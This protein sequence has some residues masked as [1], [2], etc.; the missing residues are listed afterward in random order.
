MTAPERELEEEEMVVNRDGS[1]ASRVP[2]SS[3]ATFAS[4][5]G[6]R[7]NSEELDVSATT[8][9][10]KATAA[11]TTTASVP[12]SGEN[13]TT[14]SSS[15]FKGQQQPK[16]VN[17]SGDGS[18]SAVEAVESPWDEGE[19]SPSTRVGAR[20]GVVARQVAPKAGTREINEAQSTARV[21][22]STALEAARTA[23]IS[24]SSRARRAEQLE[25]LALRDT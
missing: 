4:P 23:H 6:E 13:L 25:S 17:D 16:E 20:S 9:E 19:E 3:P 8:S 10:L 11:S 7:T 14:E 22:Q 1:S 24:Q 21:A 5:D 18:K 15:S 12:K 2:F